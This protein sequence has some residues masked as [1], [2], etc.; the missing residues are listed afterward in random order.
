MGDVCAL[1]RHLLSSKVLKEV[2]T[3][4]RFHFTCVFVHSVLPGE[5]R[6]DLDN[7]ISAFSAHSDVF[8]SLKFS[9]LL[10]HV[11]ISPSLF[12]SSTGNLP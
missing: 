10:I 6:L 5:K 8:L 9:A 11:K 2:R 1:D 12:L 3:A 4:L 7:V